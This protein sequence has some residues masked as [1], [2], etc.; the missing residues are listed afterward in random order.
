MAKVKI[1]TDSIS[2]LSPELYSKY[3]IS[4]FPL[5]INLG[6][7]SKADYAGM[8]DE[9]YEYVAKSGK[10]PK[11]AARGMEEYA[12][13]FKAS[14][15]EGGE[16]V[17]FTI[18]N[19]LSASYN[20]AAA[21]AKTMEGVYVVDSMSL[22]TGAGLSVLYACDL[23]AKGLGGKDIYQKVQARVLNSQASFVVDSLE[24]LHKG[25]RCSGVA[26]FFSGI[27][28]IKPMIMLKDG[29]MVVGKKYMSRWDKA[30][31]KYVDD[32]LS[33]YNTPDLT[34]IFITYTTAPDEVVETVKAKIKERYPFKEILV[35][36][37]GGTVT[38]HCGKNTLGIL[39]FNDGM[40]K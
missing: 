27:L 11:T 13:F 18:S 40:Q 20:N 38:S 29:K 4:M 37:A 36:R 9:I 8:P 5:M 22:S 14:K 26:A 15:P 30:V 17:H 23:A 10:T 21:A 32:V 1:S 39:Y 7:V 2:D 19:T 6:D 33:T 25:G 3:D 31:D 28:K 24:F 12:E 35:T 34:R 16:L